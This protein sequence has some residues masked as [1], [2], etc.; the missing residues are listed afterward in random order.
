VFIPLLF[1]SGLVGRMFREFALT[2]SISVVVSAVV[3]LTLTPMLCAALLRGSAHQEPEPRRGSASRLGDGLA[4]L[5]DRTL[6]FVLRHQGATLLV[7]F[8]TLAATMGLYVLMPKSFLPL[9]DTGVIS[10]VFKADPDVSFAE[11]KRL[12]GVAV[13]AARKIPEVADIVSVAGSGPLN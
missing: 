9:Q 7:T 2:L 11:M 3:S 4:A 13:T 6:L 12:Q 10:V 5:Y 1:M 8:A